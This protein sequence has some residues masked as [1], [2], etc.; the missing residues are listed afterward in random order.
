MIPLALCSVAAVAMALER[1]LA[2]RREKLAPP[3]FIGGLDAALGGNGGSAST[4]PSASSTA[5]TRKTRRV[6]SSRQVC[7][8]PR[9][10]V[11]E[12]EQRSKTPARG[13]RT[14]C[15]GGCAGCRSSPPVAPLLGLLGTVYGMIGAFQRAATAGL[16]KAEQ[17]AEGIYEALVTTAA[18]ATIAIPAL[19]LYWILRSRTDAIVDALDEMAQ[20]FA[21]RFL[22]KPSAP[23]K[24]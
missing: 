6:G 21:L 9:G 24:A 3:G 23:P 22:T 16:G 11:E 20:E 7:A 5:R 8:L 1:F 13:R 17:L 4:S 12:V 2:L 10:A 18:S 19:L 15:T 14:A